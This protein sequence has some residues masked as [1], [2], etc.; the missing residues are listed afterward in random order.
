MT[1]LDSKLTRAETD[2]IYKLVDSNKDGDIS[3]EEFIEAVKN[4]DW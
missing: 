1:Q 3:W 2:D 4:N